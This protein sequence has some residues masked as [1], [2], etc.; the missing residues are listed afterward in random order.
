MGI[1]IA[2]GGSSWTAS[3]TIMKVLRPANLKRAMA[4][5]AIVEMIIAPT[6]AVRQMM[7]LDW[8][9]V[10]KLGASMARLKLSKVTDEGQ[11]VWS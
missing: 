8:M 4:N 1:S 10:P 6:T 9:A 3:S 2:V 11:S 5:A 7:R